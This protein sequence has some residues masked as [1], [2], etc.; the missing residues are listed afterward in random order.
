MSAV[1]CKHLARP[2]PYAAAIGCGASRALTCVSGAQLQQATDIPA[3]H[4]TSSSSVASAGRRSTVSRSCSDRTRSAATWAA[5]SQQR[6]R[7]WHIGW[8]STATRGRRHDR[9]RCPLAQSVPHKCPSS[10]MH[11]NRQSTAPCSARLCVTSPCRSRPFETR[12]ASGCALS[13]KPFGS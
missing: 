2:R 9:F 12:Q 10:A 7:V 5:R 8:C 13:R 4:A 1:S 3:T 6:H 11:V